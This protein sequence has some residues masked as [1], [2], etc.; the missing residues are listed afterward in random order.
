MRKKALIVL[1][2]L[3]VLAAVY[4]LLMFWSLLPM[5]IWPLSLLAG[6]I[7]VIGCIESRR[8]KSFNFSRYALTII[9]LCLALFLLAF[10]FFIFDF[11]TGF[12]WPAVTWGLPILGGIVFLIADTIFM[13]NQDRQKRGM[14]GFAFGCTAFVYTALM[15]MFFSGALIGTPRTNP[16]PLENTENNRVITLAL[17]KAFGQ[18]LGYHI[19]F[20]STA[21]PGPGY[22]T[23]EK[24][25]G[26]IYGYASDRY[27]DGE[28]DFKTYNTSFIVQRADFTRLVDE[29]LKA[30]GTPEALAIPSSAGNGYYIDYDNR[31]TL[32]IWHPDMAWNI[33]HP[34]DVPYTRMLLPFYDED[35]GLV[36]VYYGTDSDDHIFILKYQNGKISNYVKW[37]F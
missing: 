36:M 34:S 7:V 20:P 6:I 11:V 25:K 37:N 2:I 9:N 4:L 31:Y 26:A 21:I 32:D 8:K 3:V 1:R 28:Y 22:T 5:V 27:K 12:Y 17:E 15:I 10:Y 16:A 35:S 29:F 23:L 19:I 33:V 30:N 13:V 14:R 24:I 18:G